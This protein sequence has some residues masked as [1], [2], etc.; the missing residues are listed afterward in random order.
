[1]HAY[2]LGFRHPRSGEKLVFETE[3][4]ADLAGLISVLDTHAI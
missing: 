3:P 1:L 4:P 2:R